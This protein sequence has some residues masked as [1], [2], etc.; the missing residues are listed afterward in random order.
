MLK[1]AGQITIFDGA[2][3]T[4]L[5]ER[6]FYIN[7]PFEELNLNAP[8]DV[9]AVHE[10]YVQAGADVITTNTFSITKPQLKKFDIE[11]QQ[12]KLLQ[13][14]L[15]VANEARGGTENSEAVKI[16]LSI[17]PLGVLV[18]PLGAY[19]LDE[20][21]QDFAKVAELAEQAS[22]QGFPF[23]AY[24]LETFTNVDE[25]L[26]AIDGIRSVDKRRPLLASLSVQSNDPHLIQAFA[27]R[28]G[29]REDVTALGLNCCDGPS[30][31]FTSLK[32]LLPLT[33]KP[34]VVRPNAGVPRQ[35]NGRYFYMTSPDYLAKYAKRFAE[36]G[37]LGVG[38]CCGT[39]PDHVRAIR[40]AVR[41]ANAR[42]SGVVRIT[43]DQS[44]DALHFHERSRPSLESRASFSPL[45]AR[46]DDGKKVLSIEVLPPKGTELGQ[47]LEGLSQIASA[48][49]EF[50]N[51][52]DGARA[53]TR[54]SSLHLS[55]VVQ[56]KFGGK[57]TAIPHFTTRDRNLIALQ[58][59]LLGASVANIHQVLLVTGDPPKLGNNREATGVYDIDA[60]GLTYLADCLN[61]GVTPGGDSLGS[62][63]HF[64][65]GVASNPT[66]I[67]PE[68]ELKRWNYK[69]E[70]GADYSIT[71]PIFDPRSYLSWRDKLGATDRPH[72]IG[73]WPLVS[74]RN[75][76]FMANEVPGVHVPHWVLEEMEKAGEDRLEAE[77]RGIAIAQRVMKEL[78]AHCEGFCISA[79]LGRIDT[80]LKTSGL[81]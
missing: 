29:V 19:G 39:G 31:L 54:V 1:S 18:E 43:E 75:A 13:A 30:D 14:A 21:R 4:E 35:V 66:A 57:L 25:L 40:N 12:E 38:G 5:Y 61:R 63:T 26:A 37:A 11:S 17:G 15:K 70:S 68:L 71:Q 2:V 22:Q 46:F 34:V 33:E 24:L 52:P 3:G 36:A 69:V 28:V 62:H 81:L 77:K 27:E 8:S 44:L 78:E 10:T 23:E 51:I 49:V 59:D 64:V 41:M 32:R 67:N 73:I 80:A 6:G 48:G 74:L 45:A 16:G 55:S 60:I 56:A 53:S 20:A 76:E 79:P 65:I 42:A 7:R 50:V 9:R 47:F 58:S 72:V